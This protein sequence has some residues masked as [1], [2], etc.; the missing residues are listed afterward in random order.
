MDNDM[1]PIESINIGYEG[2]EFALHGIDL[3]S[4]YY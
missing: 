2:N 3:V 4:R 1:R